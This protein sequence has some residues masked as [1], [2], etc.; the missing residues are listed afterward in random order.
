MYNYNLRVVKDGVYLD[1]KE[2]KKGALLNIEST[3][4]ALDKRGAP[5]DE[6]RKCLEKQGHKIKLTWMNSFEI[7]PF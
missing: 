7:I 6:I 5:N 3:D 1:G 2:L 4:H